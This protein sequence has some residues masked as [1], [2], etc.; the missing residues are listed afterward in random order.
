[1][2]K[3]NSFIE[4][5]YSAEFA[6]LPIDEKNSAFN[7]IVNSSIKKFGLTF[8]PVSNVPSFGAGETPNDTPAHNPLSNGVPVSNDYDEMGF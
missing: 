7:A 5:K 4:I 6:R 2:S 8:S 1:M 3:V